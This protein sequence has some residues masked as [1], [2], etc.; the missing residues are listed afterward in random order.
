MTFEVTAELGRTC[1]ADRIGRFGDGLA[2]TGHHQ[3]RIMKSHR[4]HVLH[5]TASRQCLEMHVI[6]RNAHPRAAGQRRDRNLRPKI[7]TQASEAL[8]DT[9]GRA[10]LLKGGDHFQTLR[11]YKDSIVK[12]PKNTS[13]QRGRFDRACQCGKKT[14]DAILDLGLDTVVPDGLGWAIHG[15]DRQINR[16]L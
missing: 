7:F 3:P 4:F 11:A 1:I 5:R 14:L 10:F 16:R 8:H 13:S 6:G 12:L 15:Q 9:T 2:L